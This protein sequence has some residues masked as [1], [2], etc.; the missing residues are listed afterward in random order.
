MQ[1]FQTQVQLLT[2]DVI[3]DK[4]HKLLS[5]YFCIW[6]MSIN[7]AYS[8]VDKIEYDDP[9]GKVLLSE[10]QAVCHLFYSPAWQSLFSPPCRDLS[11][12]TQAY[13]LLLTVLRALQNLLSIPATVLVEHSFADLLLYTVYHCPS[14]EHNHLSQMAFPVLN[15]SVS[16]RRRKHYYTPDLPWNHSGPAAGE[17]PLLY[18]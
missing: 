6:R 2:C 13:S 12:L 4:P 18:L 14:S 1:S 8:K 16:W 7:S 10:R 17:A 5:F 15:H 11:Y 9:W 3:L